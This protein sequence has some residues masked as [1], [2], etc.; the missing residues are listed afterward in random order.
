LR[1]RAAAGPRIV[2]DALQAAARYLDRVLSEHGIKAQC[3]RAERDVLFDGTGPTFR[4]ESCAHR[5]RS[6]IGR[7]HW[8]G[9]DGDADRFGIVDG[10]GR[11]F[12]PNHILGLLYDYLIES[13]G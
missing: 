11:W 1:G 7:G 6:G 9:D 5:R 8:C 3:L 2:F 4:E 13:R 10:A 12:S